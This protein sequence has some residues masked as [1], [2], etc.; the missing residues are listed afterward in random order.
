MISLFEFKTTRYLATAIVL[1]LVLVCVQKTTHACQGPSATSADT[2][3]SD[4]A[5]ANSTANSTLAN[6]TAKAAYDSAVLKARKLTKAC[7]NISLRFFDSSLADSYEWKK[8]WPQ[9][10]EDLAAHRPVLENAAIDWFFECEKPDEDLLK[11]AGSISAKRYD[12]GDF[13]MAWKLLEKVEQFYPDKDDVMLQRRMSLLA[14][15]TNRFDYAVN[16]MRN[17]NA[18][19]AIEELED[20]M[21][22]N[23]F[24]LFPLLYDKWQREKQLRDEE[25]EADDLPRVKLELTTGDVVVELFENEAPQAV[26]SF[27]NLVESGF[28]DGSICGPHIKGI[29]VQTGIRN[30]SPK[31][32]VNY[33]IKNESRSKQARDHFSGSLTL[34][35]LRG[36]K[37]SS[38][39]VFAVTLLPN[40]DLDWDRTEED[41]VSQPVFG[42]VVSG[43]ENI[44]ALPITAEIDEETEEQKPIENVIPG[45]IVKATV[46]R[47]RDHD[48]EFEKIEVPEKR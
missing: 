7:R 37:G 35:S 32:P 9:A 45:N 41:E 29:V 15:K 33:L 39:A 21:D 40:P 13:E 11:L 23:M 42:R 24:M 44:A 34:A 2:S 18:K 5:P 22:K 10:A 3:A 4:T 25:A 27:I 36:G 31:T 26:A 12:V 28:Y 14:M 48:Y 38:P 8:Q 16:F 46:I 1:T 20:Q 30:L 19:E 6:S 17:P 43:M 47:K